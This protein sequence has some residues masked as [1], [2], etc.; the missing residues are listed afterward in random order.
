MIPAEPYLRTQQVAKELGVSVS[1]IKRWVDSG[2]IRAAR[3]VGKHRLIPLSEA[4]RLAKEQGLPEG[5]IQ[6]LAGITEDR[7]VEFLEPLLRDGRALEAIK[8]IH[9][10]HATGRAPR[11]W[12]T[13]S[14]VP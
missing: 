10:F 11:I 4:V 8:L 2:A 9:A 7:L 5:R 6:G 12:P 1:T 3:T 13:G 14:S